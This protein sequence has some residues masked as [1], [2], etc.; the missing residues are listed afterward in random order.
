LYQQFPAKRSNE[1]ANGEITSTAGVNAA[2]VGDG[3]G[4]DRV[5]LRGSKLSLNFLRG[6][7][8]CPPPPPSFVSIGKVD[9]QFPKVTIIILLGNLIKLTEFFICKIIESFQ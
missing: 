8:K 7:K 9:T 2:A 1:Q 5:P 4:I 3:D 6:D